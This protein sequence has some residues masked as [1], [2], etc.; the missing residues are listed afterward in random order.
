[1]FRLVEGGFIV[2]KVA[3]LDTSKVGTGK[4]IELTDAV[5]VEQEILSLGGWLFL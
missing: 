1:M 5:E 2:H 4:E 3:I